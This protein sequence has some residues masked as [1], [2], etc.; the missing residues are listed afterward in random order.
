MPDLRL[1]HDI[2]L[3]DWLR[4]LAG[5][6]QA[7]GG[8]LVL[9]RRTTIIGAASIACTMAGAVVADL[10]ILHYGPVAI[11]PFVLLAFAVGVAVQAWTE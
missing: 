11:I 9:F 8:L 10:F 3:G 1:F 4:Y 6:M 5:T 2:G 7:G